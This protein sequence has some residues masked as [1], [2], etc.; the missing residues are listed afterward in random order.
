MRGGTDLCVHCAKNYVYDGAEGTG[1]G[2][3]T[4]PIFWHKESLVIYSL[5]EEQALS[6]NKLQKLVT[7]FWRYFVSRKVETHYFLIFQ[8]V[9]TVKVYQAYKFV[10]LKLHVK[11][12]R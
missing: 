2:R 3:D 7:G 6:E 5:E 11:F 8:A 4:L 9:S 10:I 1:S 12:L